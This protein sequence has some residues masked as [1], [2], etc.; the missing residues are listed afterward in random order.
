MKSLLA[1]SMMGTGMI[2]LH[3]PLSGFPLAFVSL[4]IGIEALRYSRLS[5]A[6][7]N[8]RLVLVLATCVASLGAFF[9][10]Y[11]A[12][13]DLGGVPEAIEKE[14]ST[15]HVVGR[16]LVFNSALLAGSSGYPA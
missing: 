7:P 4:L 11:Q 6:L 14:I 15:H 16:F 2:A 1:D 3:P 8:L 5:N 12:V 10:G 13:S 9:S